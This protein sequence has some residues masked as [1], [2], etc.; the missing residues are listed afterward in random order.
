MDEM[1]GATWQDQS[2]TNGWHCPLH[3]L[4]VLAWTVIV[5][6]SIVHFG[7]FIPALVKPAQLPL[8]CMTGV[9]VAGLLVTLFVSTSLDPADEAVRRK[10]GNKR[11][12]RLDRTKH[13]HAIENQTCA[14]CQVI[15]GPKSKH[16]SACNKCVSGFDHHCRW[17]NNCVGSRNYKCFFVT[18]IFA[19][20]ASLTVAT[21]G[22]LIVVAHFTDRDSGE[23]LLSYKDA[24]ETNR[25][26]KLA[27]FGED[28][29][30]AVYLTVDLITV[31]L[32]L[33]AFGFLVHLTQFHVWLMCKKMSTYDF[34][35][36]H[37][38]KLQARESSSQSTRSP[39][40]KANK[41]TPSAR[42][43]EGALSM[44]KSEEDLKHYQIALE[45]TERMEGGETPPPPIKHEKFRQVSGD[46][47]DNAHTA[48]RKIKRKKKKKHS[49]DAQI[50]SIDNPTLYNHNGY[51]SSEQAS[52]Q[53]KKAYSEARR[54]RAR[55]G[56]KT[57]PSRKGGLFPC[58]R[59]PR[60]EADMDVDDC[61]DEEDALNRTHMFSLN[62]SAQLNGDGS[63]QYP[64]GAHHPL[65]L[66]PIPKRKW[67][68]QEQEADAGGLPDQDVPPLDLSALRTS[69]D[70]SNSFRPFTG[71]SRSYDTYRF[72]SGHRQ[73]PPLR[74]LPESAKDTGL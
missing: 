38:E 37:R 8:Y 34:I 16:C 60:P 5:Y 10:G 72:P 44:T 35:V 15:V 46:G 19:I 64:P 63:L 50:S 1:D 43:S 32:A 26:A 22:I 2:R 28:V 67:P 30:D 49:D 69:Q 36:M 68:P 33:V 27:M 3:F 31:I 53:R 20:L 54:N 4:Q 39:P 9:F 61:D 71:T 65:P 21:V 70:S 55:S 13:K 12:P 17:L 11:V 74:S 62:S 56:E 52:P 66:T 40:L 23:I 51:A 57:D 7:A 42:R 6:F 25:S 47:Q 73:L 18:L 58:H 29:E 59:E 48:V 14:L 41:V 24:L 45:E